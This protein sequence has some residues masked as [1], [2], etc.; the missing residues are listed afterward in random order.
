MIKYTH[1]KF[2]EKDY[3][4]FFGEF[5]RFCILEC[6]LIPYDV[7]SCVF[8]NKL[9]LFDFGEFIPIIGK[10][11]DELEKFKTSYEKK[12]VQEKNDK[13]DFVLKG[14]LKGPLP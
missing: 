2:C 14:L 13:Y 9:H 1:S 7:E 3:C 10:T 12:R 11:E 6:E 5:L 8:E 4:S